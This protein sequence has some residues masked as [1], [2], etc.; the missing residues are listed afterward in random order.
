MEK[1]LKE[2]LKLEKEYKKSQ[3]YQDILVLLG[4][5]YYE[6]SEYEESL[7]HTEKALKLVEKQ[8]GKQDTLY[9][10]LCSDLAI[11]YTDLG[12][13]EK[14]RELYKE[15]LEIQEAQSNKNAKLYAEML[16]NS[17]MFESAVG[18]Y[19]IAIQ[20]MK[21]AKSIYKNLKLENTFRLAQKEL[22][23]KFEEPFYWGAFVLVGE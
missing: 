20:S 18:N 19:D 12:N 9:I 7:N 4:D 16:T 14:A 8:K 11:T 3:K 22:R 15:S 6:V 1:S 2:A 23:K 13:P 5:P 10:Q 17:A 21:E